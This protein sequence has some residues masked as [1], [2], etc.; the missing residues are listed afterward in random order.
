VYGYV[1]FS[2]MMKNEVVMN[3]RSR[4]GI[5][6]KEKMKYKYKFVGCVVVS[7]SC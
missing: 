3:I 1:I 4:D 6:T 2:G 5:E 7:L